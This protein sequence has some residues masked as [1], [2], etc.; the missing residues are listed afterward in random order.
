MLC[1]APWIVTAQIHVTGP[2]GSGVAEYAPY[3][4]YPTVARENHWTGSG[5]FMCKLRP[6]GTVSS[7]ELLQSTGHTL[8]DQSAL[9]ALRKWRFKVS[10]ANKVRVPI[11]FVKGG[12]QHRMAGAVIFH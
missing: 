2:G 9:D 7:V 12:V 1:C 6:D 4:K 5:I 10:E 3:P 8:L 11:R